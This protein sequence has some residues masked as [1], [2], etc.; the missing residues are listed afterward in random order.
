VILN[1]RILLS[2]FDSGAPD[3][4]TMTGRIELAAEFEQLI[5]SPFVIAELEPMILA[6]FGEDGWLAVLDEL[7]GGAWTIATIDAAHLGAM[8]EQLA[9]GVGCAAASVAALRTAS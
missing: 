4:W 3:H 7:A 5:V 9:A 6:D 8:R 2:Y 1:A